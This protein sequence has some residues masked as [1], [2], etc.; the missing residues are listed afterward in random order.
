M[1][2]SEDQLQGLKIDITRLISTNTKL[3][4]VHDCWGNET[5]QEYIDGEALVKGLEKLLKEV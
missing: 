1:E 3:K 2:G 4:E 5:V